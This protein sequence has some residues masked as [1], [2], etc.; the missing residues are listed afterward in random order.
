MSFP[1][2]DM[3]AYGGHERRG[4]VRMPRRASFIKK[5]VYSPASKERLLKFLEGAKGHSPD[6]F[7]ERLIAYVKES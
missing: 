4:E 3:R 7:V 6:G 5:N 1:D 2:P